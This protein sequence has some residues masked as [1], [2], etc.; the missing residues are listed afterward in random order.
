MLQSLW[1]C[2]A[3]AANVAQAFGHDAIGMGEISRPIQS[4]EFSTRVKLL[5]S[6]PVN[7]ES[8]E[9]LFEIQ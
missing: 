8:Y 7:I 2:P 9:I 5:M 3:K 1:D 4:H 6:F